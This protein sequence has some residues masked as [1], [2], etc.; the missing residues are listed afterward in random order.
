MKL[1][2]IANSE[3]RSI[4]T[5]I[6]DINK[7]V[8]KDN[9]WPGTVDG[10]F[11]NNG[12]RVDFKNPPEARTSCAYTL[13]PGDCGFDLNLWD[14]YLPESL[15]SKGVLTKIL[16]DIQKLQGLSGNCAVHVGINVE[17]WKKIIERAGFKQIKPS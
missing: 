3:T 16:S 9:D 13:R 5:K 14:M 15:R 6:V 17:G 8:M 4:L 7:K 1:F 2:E 10:E 11:E 12:V